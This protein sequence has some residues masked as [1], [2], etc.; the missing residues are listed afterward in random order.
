MP[1]DPANEPDPKNEP[2]DP[3]KD[4][5]PK[6]DPKEEPE[7]G[8]AGAKAIREERNA[9]KAAEKAAKA[10]QAELEKIR[11]ANQSEQEKA[12]AAAKAE[13]RT[14]ALST[15]NERLLKAEVKAAAAG[16]LADPDDAVR[17]LDLDDFDVADDGSVDTKAIKS[18]IDSL[19]KDKPY[20]AA[21]TKPG[22]LPGGGA[23]PSEGQS[24]DDW[25]RKQA[26]AG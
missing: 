1:D 13:G 22:A 14:E 25:L 7:L 15:A 20:L 8:D 5:D 19:V 6:G 26:R 9:R 16:K 12:I 2:G 10:A 21:G 23:K 18:A 17:M 3:A 4:P 24:M 11:E